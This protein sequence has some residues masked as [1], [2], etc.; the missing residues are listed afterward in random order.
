M[1]AIV[2]SE[3]RVSPL[4]FFAGA[5]RIYNVISDSISLLGTLGT[6]GKKIT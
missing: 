2:I 6:P 5:R 1:C 3:F 4:L